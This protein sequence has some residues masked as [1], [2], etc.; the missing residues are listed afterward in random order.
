MPPTD[1]T[2]ADQLLPRFDRSPTPYHAVR[3]CASVLSDAGFARVVETAAFPIG[4]GRYFLERGG[5]LAAWVIGPRTASTTGFRIV[6]AHTDSPNL[7]VK[8]NPDGSVAG[9]SQLGVDV[10]GGVLL[11]S[12]LDRDL[13]VAGRV[14]VA[15]G[16]ELSTRLFLDDRPVL[17]IPQLAIHLDREISDKGLRPNRQSHMNPTWGTIGEPEAFTRYLATMADVDPDAVLGFDAMLFDTNHAVLAGLHRDLLVSSRIDNL[18][19][20]FVAVDALIDSAEDPGA[21]IPMVCLFDHE[22]VGSVSESGA[23][24]P[25]LDT[26]IGRVVASLGGSIDDTARALAD[27][28]VVSADG[29]HAT[30]PN[31]PDRHDPAHRIEVNAGPVLKI[32]ANQ[33]Y[34]TSAESA[35]EF[36]ACC[37]DVGVPVQT[38]VNRSDLA[39]GSTIGPLTSGRLGVPVVD[40]GCA[41]LAMHSVRETAGA[42]DPQMFRSVLTRFMCR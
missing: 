6:G 22:E 1:S 39:C 20:C 5:S 21:R 33:R 36:R 10:Y 41:Q 15:D 11:N 18:L 3:E 31:Y 38:F 4:P 16:N 7:R 40:A 12:W 34:A 27:S 24:G 26:V 13:G 28:M 14:V 32:N 30:H 42:R 37:A 23:A 35:A 8:P 17:R 19:S 2:Y 9:W 25:L 29:A